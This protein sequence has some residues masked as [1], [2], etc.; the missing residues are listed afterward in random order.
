VT[1][2]TTAEKS[3][4]FLLKIGNT[5]MPVYLD[6]SNLLH[7]NINTRKRNTDPPSEASMEVG[8]EVN[9]K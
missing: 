5:P 1:F 9:A 6:D 7:K 3:I 8:L 2:T 4:S